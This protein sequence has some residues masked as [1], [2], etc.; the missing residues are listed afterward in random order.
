MRELVAKSSNI[1]DMSGV[2]YPLFP[3][4]PPFFDANTDI[5]ILFR[6]VRETMETN[7]LI[8]VFAGMLRNLIVLPTNT[9]RGYVLS[10]LSG[11]PILNNPTE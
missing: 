3:L 1:K 11:V 5:E 8:D 9:P 2:S 4:F 10:F 6:T 7:G